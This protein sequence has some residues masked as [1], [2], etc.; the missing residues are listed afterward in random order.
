M[1]E[2]S[3]SLEDENGPWSLE[4]EPPSLQDE[5]GADL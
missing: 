1:D 3:P 2:E 4:D 5:D